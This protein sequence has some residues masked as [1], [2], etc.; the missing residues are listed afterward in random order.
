MAAMG[1]LWSMRTKREKKKIGQARH[2]LGNVSQDYALDRWVDACVFDDFESH[3]P[4]FMLHK[5][6]LGDR[7]L[8]TSPR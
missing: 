5:E 4:V 6:D 3:L 7:L 2:A 8:E 1:S